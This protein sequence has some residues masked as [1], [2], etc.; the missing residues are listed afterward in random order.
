MREHASIAGKVGFPGL[1]IGGA[2][3]VSGFVAEQLPRLAA[4]LGGELLAVP[5]VYPCGVTVV[6]KRAGNEVAGSLG[7][8]K[9]LARVPSQGHRAAVFDGH[10]EDLGSPTVV[11]RQLVAECR[12][13]N[14]RGRTPVGGRWFLSAL[15]HAASGGQDGVTIVLDV[16]GEL[17]GFAV[18][19][20]VG[21]H[22]VRGGMC[23][24][25]ERGVSYDRLGIGMG[26][27]GVGVPNTM[28]HEV[29][30]AAIPHAGEVS[31][32]QVTA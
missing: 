22:S 18:E 13:H 26:V 11:D 19:P 32:G 14:R 28:L 12:D 21:D 16:V 4:V 3:Q 10:T 1:V 6:V 20:G 30:E 27:M 8:P 24:G 9:G 23:A 25:G 2:E 5:I 15:I 31:P 7:E 17:A 29:A